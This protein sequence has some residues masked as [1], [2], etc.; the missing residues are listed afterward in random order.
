MRREPG[1]LPS[2]PV[3]NPRN[4]PLSFQQQQSLLPIPQAQHQPGLNPP[5]GPQFENAKAISALRSGRVLLDPYQTTQSDEAPSS[6]AHEE[7][8]EEE[9]PISSPNFEDN[10]KRKGK[11]EESL[12]SYKPKT[13]FSQ[14]LEAG[15]EKRKQ[16]AQARNEDLM[17][18]F[19]QVHINIPLVDAIQHVPAYVKFLKELCTQKREPKIT[20][21][22]VFLSEEVSAILLN[23]YHEK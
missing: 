19:K 11:I 6:Q 5:K 12:D 15:K 7:E 22:K 16:K 14:A 2:Q 9:E 18:L 3:P 20:P 21:K 1:Q 23:T 17:D 13:P 4:Y 10:E 8:E